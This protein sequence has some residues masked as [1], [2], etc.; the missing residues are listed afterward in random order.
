MW[1][2]LLFYRRSSFFHWYKYVKPTVIYHSYPC[3]RTRPT[4]PPLHNHL[5]TELKPVETSFEA[6]D[7]SQA[8]DLVSTR[9]PCMWGARGSFHP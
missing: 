4:R 5:A 7:Y 1:A 8:A 9:A 3:S 6:C 2:C